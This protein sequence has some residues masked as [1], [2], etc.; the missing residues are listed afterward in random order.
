MPPDNTL[1]PYAAVP[2][3]STNNP[4]RDIMQTVSLH[5]SISKPDLYR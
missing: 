2:S 4:N 3:V 5:V 1:I